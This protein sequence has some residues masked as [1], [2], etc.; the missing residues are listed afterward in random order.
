MKPEKPKEAKKRA[1]RKKRRLC[2]KCGGRIGDCAYL[3]EKG[4]YH[5][6]CFLAMRKDRA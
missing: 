2:T 1:T 3:T 5:P 6:A 4:T